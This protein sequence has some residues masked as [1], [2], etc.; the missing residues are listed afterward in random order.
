M[1]DDIQ[2]TKATAEDKAIE[3]AEQQL[4]DP[5]S[6]NMQFLQSTLNSAEFDGV[7]ASTGFFNA[8]GKQSIPALNS[9]SPSFS[10]L[11]PAYSGAGLLGAVAAA[12]MGGAASAMGMA[13]QVASAAPVTF[14]KNSVGESANL[15]ALGNKALAQTDDMSKL[16]DSSPL[17]KPIANADGALVPMSAEFTQLMAMLEGSGNG[18][19]PNDALMSLIDG[20]GKNPSAENLQAAIDGVLGQ[21]S[22]LNQTFEPVFDGLAGDVQSQVSLQNGLPSTD[23]GISILDDASDLSSS[24]NDLLG[25]VDV[26]SNP[27]LNSLLNLDNTFDDIA[28]LVGSLPDLDL[29]PVTDPV[30][31]VVGGVVGG[32][33]DGIGGITDPVTDIVDGITDPVTD[34]VD[35]ITDPVTDIVDG[36]TDPVTDIVDGITDPVTDIVDG[37]TDP[38]TDIVTDITDPVTDIVTDITDPLLDPILDPILG[39]GGLLS[40]LSTS[41]SDESDSGLLDSL[42]SGISSSAGSEGGALDGLLGSL[43]P[44]K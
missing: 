11:S 10:G 18:L 23:L 6:A 44:N 9:S 33:T 20:L 28:S 32:I 2:N 30:T 31:D 24:L 15:A 27:Q 16:A 43:D 19:N 1:G 40:G 4:A 12:D 34:I 7:G 17:L 3:R 22:L 36:I 37:I 29:S 8:S 42:S 41:S 5:A 14:G 21:I 25:T 38:V 35:G 39:G 13:A 26:G